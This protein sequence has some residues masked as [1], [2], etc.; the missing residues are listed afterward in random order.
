VG[1]FEYEYVHDIWI[2]VRHDLDKDD[3]KFPSLRKVKHFNLWKSDCV[4]N[5]ESMLTWPEGI[6]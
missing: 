5:I 4:G 3:K 6:K 2:D 1:W